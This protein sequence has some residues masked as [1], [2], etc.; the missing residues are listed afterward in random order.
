MSAELFM[1]PR[2]VVLRT[3]DTIAEGARKIMAHQRRSLPVVEKNSGPRG[4]GVG[5]ERPTA[6]PRPVPSRLGRANPVT[7]WNS[8]LGR[9]W[10]RRGRKTADMLTHANDCH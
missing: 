8:R 9:R 6:K 3:D 10:R 7:P 4:L 2:P 5:M 1:N